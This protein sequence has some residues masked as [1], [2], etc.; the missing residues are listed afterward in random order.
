MEK[1][2]LQKWIAHMKKTPP[3]SVLTQFPVPT[4]EDAGKVLSVDA[5]GNPV[6]V[7]PSGGLPEITEQSKN[8]VL[9]VDSNGAPTWGNVTE[10]GIPLGENESICIFK[11]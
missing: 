5:D 2:N 1:T 9:V 8:K 4:G 10:G 6:W 11:E 7:E 3:E